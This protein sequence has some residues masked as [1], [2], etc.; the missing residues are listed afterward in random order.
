MIKHWIKTQECIL[1]GTLQSHPVPS[2]SLA[3]FSY[4]L[5]CF[6]YILKN[7]LHG[8]SYHFFLFNIV[9][10]NTSTVCLSLPFQFFLVLIFSY[11]FLDITSA[12]FIGHWVHLSA[13]LSDIS[14]FLYQPIQVNTAILCSHH[15]LCTSYRKEEEEGR[16]NTYTPSQQ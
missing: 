9:L 13:S 8:N 16:P 6:E 1:V 4:L 10:I 11:F 7:W 15:C 3:P 5:A 2:S 14:S 12:L